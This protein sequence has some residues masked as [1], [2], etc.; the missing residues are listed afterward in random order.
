LWWLVLVLL[1]LLDV[2]VVVIGGLLVFV[3]LGL[4]DVSVVVIGGLL[5]VVDS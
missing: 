5:V 4:L 3:L 2:S 1:V